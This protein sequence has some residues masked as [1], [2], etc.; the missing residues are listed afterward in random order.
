MDCTY[1]HTD[2]VIWALALTHLTT[3]GLNNN[4]WQYYKSSLSS[5]ELLAEISAFRW[6]E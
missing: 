4:K 3:L 5:P 6:P 1:R 2:T